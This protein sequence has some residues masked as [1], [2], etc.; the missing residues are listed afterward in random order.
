MACETANS[1]LSWLNQ[2]L[3]MCLVG[4]IYLSFGSV[5]N[6]VECKRFWK[7]LIGGIFVLVLVIPPFLFF[8]KEGTENM[9]LYVAALILGII[10]AGLH[11]AHSLAL[12]L[13]ARTKEKLQSSVPNFHS[14]VSGSVFAEMNVKQAAARKLAL[15]V[16]NALDL[17]ST[18]KDTVLNSHYGQALKNYA[19]SWKK[20]VRVGGFWWAW[21]RIAGH[22]QLFARD[23][24]WLPA[25]MLAGNIAQYIVVVYT[26]FG[27]IALTTHVLDNFDKESAKK[28]FRD[29]VEDRTFSV[30]HDDELAGDWAENVSSLV[31]RYMFSMD[32]QGAAD[33]GCEKGTMSAE[34]VIDTYC[35]SL[36]SP[37]EVNI[38]GAVS[39]GCSPNASVNYLCP[40]LDP[41]VASD[42]N[43][44]TQQAL[45]AA[46]GFDQEYL[47]EAAKE[48]IHQ[49]ADESVDSL[50]PS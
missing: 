4:V 20:H 29:F 48:F 45:L 15:M 49:A 22:K 9:I 25:R 35:L 14:L 44:T 27:G 3:D 38:S 16:N 10:T 47:E 34:D 21:Q 13:S 8:R 42:L 7:P 40:L 18:E 43:S 23:G 50:Y 36:Q 2:F 37:M 5:G 32:A 41:A 31:G 19:Q 24:I 1:V 17:K 6:A 39:V 30:L 26:L 11:F 12:L 28:M 46:S 33:F